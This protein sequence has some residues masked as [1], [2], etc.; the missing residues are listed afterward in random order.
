MNIAVC[1]NDAAD[2]A[3]IVGI[4]RGYIDDNGYT[5]EINAFESGEDLLASF[6]VGLYDVIFLDIYMGG[7]NG[8]ETAKKI[9]EVDPTCV[10]IFI[11]SSPDHALEGFSVRASAYVVKP[12]R[13]KEMQTALF[14]CRELFLRNAKYIEIRSERADMKL[15]LIKIYY[16]ESYDKTALFHTTDGI[17]KTR[18]SMDEIEQKLGG[19]PFLRCHQSYLIN[20]NHI[21]KLNGQ[22]VHMKNGDSVPIRQRGRDEIRASIAEFLSSR[23]FEVQ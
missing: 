22:E 21:S 11:T 13:E 9:R 1:E 5:G 19:K 8:V 14:Q 18:M 6:F 7:I 17:Y 16:A 20:M 23:V 4:L 12:I 15:P 2:S 10:L 3:A